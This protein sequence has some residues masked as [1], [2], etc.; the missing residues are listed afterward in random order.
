MP[1]KLKR[2]LYTVIDGVQTDAPLH[3]LTEDKTFMDMVNEMYR[4]IIKKD[5]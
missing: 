4:T 3:D 1:E 2:E 5:K